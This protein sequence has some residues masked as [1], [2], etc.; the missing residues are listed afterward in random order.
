MK[1]ICAILLC[2]SL[3]LSLFAGCSTDKSP[4][5]TV[6]NGLLPEQTIPTEESQ[7]PQEEADEICLVYDPDDSFNPYETTGYTNRVLF[8]LIY[9]GLFTVSADYE[10]SPMLCKSY[11]VSADQ[12]T[13]TFYLADANFSDGT[14]VTAADVAASLKA[15]QGSAWYGNRLQHVSSIG[16]YGDAVVLELDTPMVNLPIL[17]DIPIVKAEQ[18]QSEKPLG[19]GPYQLVGHQLQRQAAWWCD[20]ALSFDCDTID[21]VS[22]ETSAAIRDAFEFDDVSLVLTDPSS[23]DY[24][25]FHSDY[26]LWD[27]ENGL[28]LYLVCNG[29]YGIFSNA[30]LRAALTHAIDRD[31][32]VSTYYNG[33]AYSATLPASPKSPWYSSSL[34]NNYGRDPAKFR[35]VLREA[36]PEVM[37]ITL[38]VNGENALR[39]K[40]GKA[41]AAML[42]EYGFTVTLIQATGEDYAYLLAKGNYDLYLAQTR[43]S[44]N[45]DLSAFFGTNSSLSYGNLSDP[46]TY[47]TCLEALADPDNYYTLYEMIMNDGRLCPILF[48][49]YAI[50]VQRGALSD[51]AP[52]RDNIFYYDLGTS[53]SDALMSE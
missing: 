17:L 14:A 24:V 10:V 27:C 13:Y 25:S 30:E 36:A 38:L 32:L 45:M 9:Q 50:Y 11:N 51:F 6:S 42:E 26:E 49:T 2:V 18:V 8:S 34:A 7:R 3:M 39:V 5:N 53:L 37:E 40:I 19:T 43:L 48:Q 21:L 12:R 20:A 4:E 23:A 44:N 46:A 35:Q 47:A 22:G 29:D 15:A 52:A 33:F 1:H 28:F 16:S 31:A 41:I